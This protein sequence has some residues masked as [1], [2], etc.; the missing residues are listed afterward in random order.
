MIIG[1][2]IDFLE[3]SFPLSL[4]EDYDNSG[5]L[6]GRK[7]WEATSVL[8]CLD[9]IE[10]VIDEAISLGSNLI[11]AHHPI[12]FKGLKK[13]T[14]SNYVERV[15]EKCVENKIA[16]Y[17]I[18]TN[19]D[20]HFQGV[21]RAIANRIGLNDLRI[22]SP[23]QN[24]LN[25]LVVFVPK[26]AIDQLDHAIFD[27]GGGKIGNYS[28]CHFRT[29][30]TGTFRPNELA[31]PTIGE[32]NNRSQ[33]E[34]FRVEYLVSRNK[35]SDV[36]TAMFRAHPYEDVAYEIYPIENVNQEEGAGMIGIL[37]EPMSELAFL[38]L[39]KEKFNCEIIRHTTLLGKNISRVAIC[40]GAGS[41]LLKKAIQQKADIFI[42]ADFKYHEFFDAENKVIIADIGHFESEQFTSNLIADKLKEK[43]TN[44]AIRLTK[45][46][47]NP[48]NYF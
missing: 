30:G 41:F 31:N 9:A 25:K 15:I 8:V 10:S 40:G 48:I 29:S 47:T 2:I 16:L 20:N 7:D 12:I 1:D 34:E 14:G 23:M 44:F 6:C 24:S 17:A 33:V 19:L 22:L 36:L 37:N 18:H 35:I 38:K 28:E 11:I 42:T 46:N 39:I 26:D 21:N 13:I 5:L 27:A 4:Q 45:I 43:F 3:D 32:N